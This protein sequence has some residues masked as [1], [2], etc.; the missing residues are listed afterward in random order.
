MTSP[1]GEPERLR[2]DA[3]KNRERIVSAA[4]EAFAREGADATLKD[5]AQQAGV[6]IGTLYRHFPTREALADAVYRTETQR[7]CDAAAELLQ[8]HAPLD[9]LREWVLLFLDYMATKDGMAESLH[10]VLTADA[11]LRTDTR[12]RLQDA[13]RLLVDAGQRAGH[14]RTPLDPADL[15]LALAGL[16]LALRHHPDAPRIAPRLYTLLLDGLRRR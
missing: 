6:G 1:P 13:L 12:A 5:I 7:L 9:A 10:A 15:S 14:L 4:A 16:A 8:R 3:R 2:A 11:S